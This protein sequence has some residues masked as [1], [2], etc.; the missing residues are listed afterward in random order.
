[1]IDLHRPGKTKPE[2]TRKARPPAQQPKKKATGKLKRQVW[3]HCTKDDDAS[4]LTVPKCFPKDERKFKSKFSEDKYSSGE[5]FSEGMG[6]LTIGGSIQDTE[7]ALTM[8]KDDRSHRG[9]LSGM[10]GLGIGKAFSNLFK[11]PKPEND[12]ESETTE[13]ARAVPIIRIPK[14]PIGAGC[15]IA[16][17]P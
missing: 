9:L 4:S 6:E 2:E 1:M 12:D 14:T 15:P 17:S 13:R 8:H 5:E 3:I 7:S 11:K 16:E 10:G